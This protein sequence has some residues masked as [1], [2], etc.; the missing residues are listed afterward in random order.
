MDILIDSFVKTAN[1]NKKTA[2]LNIHN[3]TSKKKGGAPMDN[4]LTATKT[5]PILLRPLPIHNGFGNVIYGVNGAKANGLAL[6]II[7]DSVEHLEH[8][9]TL[10]G[11]S[12]YN[13]FAI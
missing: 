6:E 2:K 13:D 3:S 5:P 12:L 8:L 1:V 11:I 10:V 9:I 4:R 7:A